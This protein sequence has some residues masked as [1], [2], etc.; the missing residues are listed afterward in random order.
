MP[1]WASRL[2]LKVTDVRI[3]KLNELRKCEE[4]IK[5]EGFDS[6]PRFKHVWEGIYGQSNPND[7]VWVIEF[8]VIH[9]NVDEYLESIKDA[10]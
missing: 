9:L 10:A 5:K 7:Y 6:W 8:E 1:R 4:Q 3:E 2:T